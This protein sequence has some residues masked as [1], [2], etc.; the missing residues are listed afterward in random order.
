LKF[1]FAEKNGSFLEK[2]TEVKQSTVRNSRKITSFDRNRRKINFIDEDAD[3]ANY[4]NNGS[5]QISNLPFVQL[6]EGVAIVEGK[7]EDFSMKESKNTKSRINSASLTQRNFKSYTRE[8][9]ESSRC[10]KTALTT[11][12]AVKTRYISRGDREENKRIDSTK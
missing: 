4:N 6:Q 1:G 10:I 11:T 5:R 8:K 9:F 2:S 7:S 3:E 12:S